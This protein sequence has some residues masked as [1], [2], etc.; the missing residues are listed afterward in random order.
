MLLFSFSFLCFSIDGD[1]EGGGEKD[2]DEERTNIASVKV[3]D[4]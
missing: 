4:F 1:R 3:E 2:M